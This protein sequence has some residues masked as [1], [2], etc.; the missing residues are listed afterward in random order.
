MPSIKTLA[1]LAATLLSSS[2]HSQSI[3]TIAPDSVPL[4]TRQGWC[5]SQVASCPL[6]CL[7]L[8]GE[9]STTA[10]NTCDAESLSYEC[11]CGNDKSPNATEFSQTLPF[12]ECQE[13]GNQ[14]VKA[15]NGNT[16]CQS[17]CRADHPCGAQNPTRVNLTTST[18]S[19]S[20]NLPAGATTAPGGAVVYNGLGGGAA[21]TTPAAGAQPT[22]NDSKSGSQMA[23]DIGRSY[24]SAVV[25]AGLF[26]GFALVM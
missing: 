16:P 22:S 5:S 25:F 1:I 12:F 3:Y 11:I 8:Q 14:C 18:S 10:V 20:T 2:V 17:A 23:M 15:C 13:Y 21:A 19:S 24:S 4:P 26:A 7:Q 6:L 9:S